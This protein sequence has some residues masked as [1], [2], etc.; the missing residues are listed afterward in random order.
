MPKAVCII[1]GGMDSTL[2]AYMAQK[3]G[4]EI[5]AVHFNYGQRTQDKELEAFRA[6][7][8]S[9]NIQNPYEIDLDFF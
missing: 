7:S 6:V 5:I 4:L 8:N 9:L 2:A 1:S 3:D